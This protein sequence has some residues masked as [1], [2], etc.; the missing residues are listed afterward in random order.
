[1][2]SIVVGFL[3]A[4]TNVAAASDSWVCTCIDEAGKPLGGIAF[5]IKM[6]RS[7]A[8]HKGFGSCFLEDP[9]TRSV[10]CEKFRDQ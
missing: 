7:E 6:P 3:I 8:E 9:R 5:D 10:R 2:T 1:M 4:V